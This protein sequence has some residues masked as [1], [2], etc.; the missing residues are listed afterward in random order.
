MDYYCVCINTRKRVPRNHGAGQVDD[1]DIV[2]DG[3]TIMWKALVR[4]KDNVWCQNKCPKQDLNLG[5]MA[6]LLL[7]FE[8]GHGFFTSQL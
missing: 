2:D 4:R 6:F 1:D 3:E 5:P 7:E 8:I